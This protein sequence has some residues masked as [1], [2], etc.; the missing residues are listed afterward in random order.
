MPKHATRLIDRRP[1]AERTMEFLFERPAGFDFKAG[2]FVT[3][4]LPD[5][6]FTDA[7]GNRP[8]TTGY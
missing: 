2:Q 6:P 1:V 3:L 5:P 8:P 4:I 7:R